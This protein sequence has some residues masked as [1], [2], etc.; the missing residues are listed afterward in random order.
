MKTAAAPAEQLLRLLGLGY[1][2]RQVVLGVESVRDGLRAGRF[3]CVVV[4]GDASPRARDKVVRLAAAKGIPL[5]AG[6]SAEAIGTRLGK[7]GVMVAGVV[8]RALARGIANAVPA[9]APREA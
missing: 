4:A 7:P 9:A 3:A 6:P 5:I 8:D 2:A 1:R